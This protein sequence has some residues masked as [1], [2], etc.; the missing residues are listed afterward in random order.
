MAYL[1][2]VRHGTSTYNEKG[3]WAGWDD[4][5]LTE[6]GK[7][8]AKEAGEHLK[9]IN[10]DEGYVS[11]LQRH[12]QTLDIILETVNETNIHITVSNALKERDYGDF[13]AKNKWDVKKK[14]GDAEF[15]KLRRGW[16]YPVP[17][18]E[19]LKQVYDREI[20]YYESTIL[21]QLKEG[22][23]VIIAGSGNNLRA[24]VKYLEDVSDDEISKIQIAPGEIYLYEVNEV[25]EIVRKEIRNHHELTV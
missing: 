19:S 8:D 25:G 15:L 11:D 4:P 24:L 12:K 13:T 7:V 14:L 23:N 3:L 5:E 9:D 21:P 2:L 17:N 18:G 6:Q 20:P 22:K 10:F 1:A 16:D